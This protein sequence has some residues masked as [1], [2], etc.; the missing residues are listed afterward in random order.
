ML[1]VLDVQHLMKAA[2]GSLLLLVVVAIEG[3]TAYT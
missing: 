1:V 2:A 3:R